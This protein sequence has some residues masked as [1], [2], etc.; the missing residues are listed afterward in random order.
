MH[1]SNLR[2][3]LVGLAVYSA[4]GTPHA[5]WIYTVLVVL[6]SLW[7]WWASGGMSLRRKLQLA[8]WD[9][10]REGCIHAKLSLD[11][12]KVQEYIERKRKETQRHITLTHVVGKTLGLAL[13]QAPGL[14]GRI[15][16]DRFLPFKTIDISFLA[17]VE[18]GKNL[19]KVKIEDIDH[20]N[21]EEIAAKLEAGTQR[22]RKGLDENFK[23]T[24]G[25]LNFLP[26]WL[27]RPVVN[28]AAYAAGALGMSIPML[29][30]EPHP[31]GAC[32]VTSVGM[33]GV[34]EAFAPFTPFARV[35]LLVLVGAIH[36]GVSV[37]DGQSKITQKLKLCCTIDHRFLDGVQGGQ[38]IK[39]MRDVFADPTMLDRI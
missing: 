1:H 13:R 23:K 11:A 6:L 30:V 27:I 37:V 32:V 25:P 3:V 10:P 9:E 19:A 26:T 36:D 2:L 29:G 39:V 8:T 31:F 33:L 22:L 24:M 15:V 34:D 4:W 14:N 17:I 20:K 18:G 21:I 35:P 5:A 7:F 12:T 16:L 38:M 28:I